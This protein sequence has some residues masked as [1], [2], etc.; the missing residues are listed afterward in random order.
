MICQRTPIP[1]QTS[2]RLNQRFSI[3]IKACPQPM[4]KIYHILVLRIFDF[5]IWISGLLK[6]RIRK[7]DRRIIA[8]GSGN[9]AV[10]NTLG[11]VAI[12]AIFPSQS[13]L[14][15]TLN[16]LKGL[17]RHGFFILAVSDRPVRPLL[18]D[19]LMAHCHQLIER[20][21]I[22][23]DF[24]SYRMGWNWLEKNRLK[25]PDL[26]ALLMAND[27]LFYPKNIDANIASMLDKNANWQCLFQGF[28]FTPHA[29]SYFLMFRPQVFESKAFHDFW[30]QYQG[31]S[32]RK[33]RVMRG[34]I[35]LSA[36][37]LRAGFNIHA[38]YTSTDLVSTLT[39]SPQPLNLM[40]LAALSPIAGDSPVS[41]EVILQSVASIFT[42]NNYLTNNKMHEALLLIFKKF[43]Y[44]IGHQCETG[45]PTH[46][47]GLLMNYLFGAPLKRDACFRGAY[48]IFQILHF[49][50]GYDEAELISMREDLSAR[51]LPVS[52]TGLKKLL[53]DSGRI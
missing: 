48:D 23:A 5:Y 18:R 13:S 19:I 44:M 1:A 12:I 29:Q 41:R 9:A 2:F 28:E 11:R 33:H 7:L 20:A 32:S 31:L 36:T 51:A 37:L 17:Q 25:F 39:A 27:S 40:R 52:S 3:A 35:A 34:E 38:C 45:N 4:T 14:P 30:A 47:A 49:A 42:K 46:E 26:N 22:G 10:P 24:A 15:F 43:A 21:G 16:L 8:E 50:S 6:V 53:I